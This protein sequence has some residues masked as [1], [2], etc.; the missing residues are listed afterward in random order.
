LAQPTHQQ[1]PQAKTN[2]L[3]PVLDVYKW[4][5]GFE[6]YNLNRHQQ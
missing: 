1:P 6:F 3:T 5:L 2:I 4:Q